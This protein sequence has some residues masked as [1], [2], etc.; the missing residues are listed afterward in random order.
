MTARGPGGVP[1]PD[2]RLPGGVPGPDPRDG[3]RGWW[4]LTL[5][6]C[7]GVTTACGAGALAVSGLLPV[8][9]ALLGGALAVLVSWCSGLLV[10]ALPVVWSRLAVALLV[11][12]V[13]I[14]TA[15][16]SGTR[17]LVLFAA[18]AL[19]ALAGTAVEHTSTRGLL[20]GLWLGTACV[21]LAVGV[22]PRGALAV[23][24]LLALAALLTGLVHWHRLTDTDRVGVTMRPDPGPIAPGAADPGGVPSRRVSHGSRSAR[25]RWVVLPVVSCL[26]LALV[27]GPVLHRLAQMIDLPSPAGQ[28]RAGPSW[29]EGSGDPGQR[30]TGRGSSREADAYTSGTMDLRARGDLPDTG[31]YA[32]PPD[33]PTLWRAAVLDT[34]DGH[35]WSSRFSTGEDVDLTPLGRDRVILDAHPLD[36]RVGSAPVRSAPVRLLAPDAMERWP[37]VISP[38][39]L[40]AVG[41]PPGSAVRSGVYRHT[42]GRILLV[43]LDGRR[44]LEHYEVTWADQPDVRAVPLPGSGGTAETGTGQTVPPGPDVLPGDP[45]LWLQLPSTVPSRVRELGRRL[46]S[47]APTRR[48]AVLAVEDHLRAR[49]TY[50][51][52]SPVPEEGEDAV[53][54]FLF[55][56]RT[57]FCEQFASA[58]VVLLRSAGVPARLATGFAGGDSTGGDSAGGPWRTLRGSD[59]HAWVEVWFPERGWVSSDPTAGTRLAPSTRERVRRALAGFLTSPAGIVVVTSLVLLLLALV[60]TGVRRARRRRAA[61]ASAPTGSPGHPR[62]VDAELVEALARLE[63]ALRATG[64]PREPG[65]TLRDLLGRLPPVPRATAWGG[66]VEGAL[67]VLERA[68]YGPTQ[69]TRA[70]AGRAAAVLDVVTARVLAVAQEEGAAR[71]PAGARP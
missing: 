35:S 15:F 6:G 54:D 69:P 33:T 40:V 45:S 50:R 29:M 1:G 57:G 25:G 16:A 60:G 66:G 37:S 56:S 21:L 44:V 39:P 17:G 38:G 48:E 11:Q 3:D 10:A 28:G 7:V 19:A 67:G 51:L 26:L 18:V 5:R 63:R 30:R 8:G 58:E 52:D 65:E 62:T 42:S 31:L 55:D 22:A 49:A 23:P 12:G 34:Y 46:V 61:G 59:A 53:D 64:A 47:G 36:P 27:A 2:P 71:A 4:M 43:D 14:G 41:P 68:L 13:V 32:V 24:V 70:E 9:V 20:S